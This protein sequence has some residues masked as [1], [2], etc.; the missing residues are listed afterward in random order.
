MRKVSFFIFLSIRQSNNSGYGFI[1]ENAKI[2]LSTFCLFNIAL[3][4]VTFTHK[5]TTKIES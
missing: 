1:S 4:G 3:P 2:L 5:Q